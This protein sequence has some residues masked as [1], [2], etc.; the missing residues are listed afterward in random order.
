[1]DMTCLDL[2]P[3]YLAKARENLQYWRSKR[4][5][6]AVNTDEFIQVA[7]VPAAPQLTVQEQVL[8]S[9]VGLGVKVRARIVQ[10]DVNL[11]LAYSLP[12]N[13]QAPVGAVTGLR[14]PAGFGS[15]HLCWKEV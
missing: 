13:L 8:R 7:H 9:F 11:P 2:S 3:F 6:G 1:M 15:G 4:A 10:C 12:I 14:L 5:P